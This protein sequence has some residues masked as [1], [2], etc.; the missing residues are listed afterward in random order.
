MG[1]KIALSFLSSLSCALAPKDNLKLDAKEF[2]KSQE[3]T[4]CFQ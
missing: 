2:T 1:L 3:F 4:G